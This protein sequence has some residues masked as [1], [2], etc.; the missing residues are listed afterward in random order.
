LKYRGPESARRQYWKLDDDAYCIKIDEDDCRAFIVATVMMI[1]KSLE[2]P[3]RFPFMNW[4]G[5]PDIWKFGVLTLYAF[6]GKS[7]DNYRRSR[8][9]WRAF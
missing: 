6:T 4:G 7:W 2:V 5:V 8:Q 9:G 1:C 3:E